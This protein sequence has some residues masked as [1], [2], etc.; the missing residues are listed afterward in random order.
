MGNTARIVMGLCLCLMA[1]A[2]M[3]GEA[4]ANPWV[5]TYQASCLGGSKTLDVTCTR[6][7]EKVALRFGCGSRMAEYTYTCHL[8]EVAPVVEEVPP[9]TD[10]TAFEWA[11]GVRGF[12]FGI[13][14]GPTAFGAVGLLE[15]RLRMKGDVWFVFETGPGFAR[16]NSKIH[17]TLTEHAGVS[18]RG[19]ALSLTLGAR[20]Q[21]VFDGSTDKVN[22][23]TGELA[24]GY[25]LGTHVTLSLSGGI[26]AA[27]F[28]KKGPAPGLYP[29][30]VTPP[31]ETRKGSG[32]AG[33]GSVGLSYSF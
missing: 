3:S 5:E 2:G 18:W 7:G 21:I 20:H 24:V 4:K 33:G 8:P 1:L 25:R 10:S 13:K 29:A 31:E 32:L 28:G 30:G 23:V 12:G 14:G 16:L 19:D 9:T 27:W 11:L 22:A 26:G 17:P 15:V 6:E